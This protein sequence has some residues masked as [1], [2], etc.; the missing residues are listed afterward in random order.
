MAGSSY[1]YVK[2]GA[3]LYAV[4]HE[5]VYLVLIPSIWGCPGEFV[6]VAMRE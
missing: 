4:N 6:N 2:Q 1:F 3:A 5:M